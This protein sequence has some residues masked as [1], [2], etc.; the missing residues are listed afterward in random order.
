MSVCN[1]NKVEWKEVRE[2]LF[3]FKKTMDQ[4]YRNMM[5]HFLYTDCEKCNF[6][7]D[8]YTKTVAHVDHVA[9]QELTDEEMLRAAM[10]I[11]GSAE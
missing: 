3:W 7:D 6:W 5:W 9:P 4:H 11:D 8:V 2:M 1:D 10:E